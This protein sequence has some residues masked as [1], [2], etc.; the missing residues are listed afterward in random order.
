MNSLTKLLK[1]ISDRFMDYANI[2]F[3]YIDVPNYN[4]KL[5]Y[6]ETIVKTNKKRI[7]A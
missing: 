7:S 2:G 1:G 3:R 5:Y 6:S 4:E